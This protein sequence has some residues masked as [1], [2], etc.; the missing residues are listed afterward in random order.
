[1]SMSEE[2]SPYE[3]VMQDLSLAPFFED[4]FDPDAYV[5]SIIRSVSYLFYIT[6]CFMLSFTLLLCYRTK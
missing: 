1:M 3:Q 5:R 6:G 2:T 4:D